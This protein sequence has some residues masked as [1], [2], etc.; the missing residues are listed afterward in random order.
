MKSNPHHDSAKN[1]S[2]SIVYEK[3]GIVTAV[4]NCLTSA[5]FPYIFMFLRQVVTGNN[6][7]VWT[8]S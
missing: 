2:K 5:K 7:T 6:A 4:V 8:Y 1:E 3:P